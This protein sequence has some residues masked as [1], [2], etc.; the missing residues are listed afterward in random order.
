M[1]G[2]SVQEIILSIIYIY[3]TMK[4]VKESFN[5]RV[6]TTIIFLILI[7]VVAIL[8]D[9]VVIALDYAQYFMLKAVIHSFVYAFKLQLEFVILNEFREVIAKGGLAPLQLNGIQDDRVFMSTP[10]HNGIKPVASSSS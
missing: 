8:C 2:F 9:V 3:G 7:Q 4:M 5:P 6:R 10:P 1:L